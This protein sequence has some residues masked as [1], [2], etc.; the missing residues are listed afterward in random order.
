MRVSCLCV[1][2]NRPEFM[3]WMLWNYDR[4]TWPE[5]E[6]V[7]VDSSGAPFSSGRDDVRVSVRTGACLFSH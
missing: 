5:R 4:Q 2:E 3:D 6:L 7:V 1:T